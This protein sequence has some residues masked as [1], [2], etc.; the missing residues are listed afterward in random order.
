MSKLTKLQMTDDE[1]VEKIRTKTE[2]L[3]IQGIN[4]KLTNV[5]NRTIK[6]IN[7]WRWEQSDLR[8]LTIYQTE[9][10]NWKSLVLNQIQQT[11]QSLV[12]EEVKSYDETDSN[13]SISSAA[14][15]GTN[16]ERSQD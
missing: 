2:A 11:L 8:V 15:E 5:I 13:K 4:F 7:A 16:R 10:L 1:L 3:T 14:T 12:K 9:R 6:I